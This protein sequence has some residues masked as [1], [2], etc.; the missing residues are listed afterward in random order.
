MSIK[1]VDNGYKKY[2]KAISDLNKSRIQV[3]LFAE[4]GD[5]VLTRAIVN[6]FGTTRAGKNK[7]ITI[8]ERSFIRATYN[9]QYKIVAK[10][11]KQIFESFSKRKYDVSNRLKLIGMEQTSETQKTITNF[12]TPANAPSTIKSKGSSH[13]LIDTGEMRMKIQYKVIEK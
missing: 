7:N 3:G 8:P 4:V 12:K 13:P 11:F 5:S 1:E 10:R 6:E 2:V 9:E